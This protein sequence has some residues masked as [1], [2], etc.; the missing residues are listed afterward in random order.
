MKKQ[1]HILPILFL[2][3]ISLS[4]IKFT[5][6]YICKSPT[7]YSYHK[8]YCQGLKQCTHSIDSVTVDEAKALGKNRPCG[9]CYH[10]R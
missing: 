4:A 8:G 2:A 9:Y 5:K 1:L 7:S 6:V 3:L 10:H